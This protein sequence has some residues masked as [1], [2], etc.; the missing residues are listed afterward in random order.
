MSPIDWFAKHRVA[1]NL[2]MWVIAIGGLLTLPTITREVF[3]DVT[4]DLVTV[5][6]AYPGASPGEV[7][8]TIVERI[9]EQLDGLVGVRRLTSTAGEGTGQVILELSNSADPQRTLEDVKTRVDALASLPDGAEE[10]I[11]E[12]PLIRRQVVNIAI[13]GDVK[14]KALKSTAERVRDEVAALPE[15]TNVE[16]FGARADEITVE[17]SE[18]SLRRHQLTFDDVTGSIARASLDLP[19]GILRTEAGDVRLRTFGQARTE[20]EFAR[21]PLL[22]RPDGTRLSLG[23][24]A[25]IDDGFEEAEQDLRFEGRPAILVRVYRVGSQSALEISEAVR[26]YVDETA[27]RLPVGVSM[28]VYDDSSRILRGRLETLTRNARSGLIL[29][30]VSLTLFLKP[31]LAFWVS[32]GIPI[33]FLGALWLMPTFDATLNLVSLFGFILVLGILVDD[34][35]VVGENVHRHQQAGG[36]DR[37]KATIAGT[38]EVAAPV[39]FG[40]LTTIVAFTPMLFVDG[41]A[42]DIW[43]QI[44]IVVIA[45]LLFSLV[46][47]FWVLPAH[48]GHEGRFNLRLPKALGF[49]ERIPERVGAGLD[50][51]VERRFRPLLERILAARYE[52]LATAAALV[53]IAGS[54]IAG[55]WIR[56]TFFPPIE[57]D[58]VV[59]SFSLPPGTAIETTR[60]TVSRLEASARAVTARFAASPANAGAVETVVAAVGLDL[61]RGGG[62]S[63]AT[64][65]AKNIGSVEVSLGPAEAR[66]VSTREYARA[67]REATGSIPGIEELTFSSDLFSAGEPID[68]ELRG[69]DVDSLRAVATSLGAELAR[70]PGVRDV[71]DSYRASKNELALRLKKQAEGLGLSVADLA[72]QV[73]QAFL[74][75]E[76]QRIARDGQDVK[77]MVRYP[78]SERRALGDVERLRIRTPEGEAVALSVVADIEMGEGPASIQRADG[79]RVVNVRADVD[80]SVTSAGEVI[81]DLRAN[82]LP[83]LLEAYPGVRYA[84]E[85][86]QREQRESL[87][88]LGRGFLFAL[89][90]IFA[91]LAIPLRS[92]A[93]PLLVMATIPLGAVGAIAG[94]ALLGL[95]LSFPSVIGVVALSGVVVND[96]LVLVDWANRGVKRG[97][98]IHQAALEAGLSR[99]RPVFLTSLTT[100]LGLMPLLLE[101]SVQAQFLIPMAVSIAAGVLMATLVSLLVVPAAYLVLA[102]LAD[103][104]GGERE[105]V[106]G[107]AAGLSEGGAEGVVDGAVGR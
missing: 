50:H 12:R 98:S 2:L 38:R 8:S 29:V 96:S 28:S 87:S 84:L 6:V 78:E 51:W 99:F 67:W 61:G 104:V 62:S 1:A 43:R 80:A 20:E 11:V 95:P 25:N 63:L 15:I 58:K 102:D 45:A 42:G 41:A 23:D 103:L 90:A 91:L 85:G 9:E 44:P 32:A 64:A 22:T 19:G 46:K 52:T 14:E 73:R 72:R 82:V 4:P 100:S 49:V 74:G 107:V 16:V 92:Y 68:I 24:V 56:F 21:L 81:A 36:K 3:P 83:G 70:R 7:E 18:A 97:L 31:R 65:P 37:M 106:A 79:A 30:L 26:D 69:T 53:L 76:V 86:E 77:V 35:I 94:H 54:A 57:G 13:F 10:P 71:R 101:Q 60:Q 89:I 93:Q 40:V 34:A 48:L 27:A 33:S 55:G 39:V 66:E 59:A 105:L 17:V 47:C 88:D 5:S 75:E